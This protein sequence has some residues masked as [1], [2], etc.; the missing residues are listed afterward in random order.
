MTRDNPLISSQILLDSVDLHKLR[1]EL[2][3]KKKPK[4]KAKR[5]PWI[6]T[7]GYMRSYSEDGTVKLHHRMVVENTIGRPLK[8]SEIVKF[9]DGN[10]T[11]CDPSNLILTSDLGIDLS[12]LTCPHCHKPF[13]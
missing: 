6:S 2:L 11:N 12:T 10:K 1:K 8:R 5:P 7:D 9:K 3:A 4:A 13:T